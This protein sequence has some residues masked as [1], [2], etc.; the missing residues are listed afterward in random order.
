MSMT[1]FP[2]TLFV[3]AVFF[4]T[5]EGRASES[6]LSAKE[7]VETQLKA[8]KI[9]D[10]PEADHGI[11]VAWEYAH[12]GNQA[13]TGPLPRFTQ[14]L[15]NPAYKPLLNHK[16]HHVRKIEQSDSEAAF[17]VIVV[18]GDGSCLKY[19]WFVERIDLN[20]PESPWRT[21]S[22]STPTPAPEDH[23]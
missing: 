9:N 12:P 15:Y 23:V 17:E 19:L 5:V 7:V 8:L 1:A 6:P 22:V 10:T 3:L 13:S 16:S 20:D 2:F 21:T 11:R 18:A 14:M 4:V